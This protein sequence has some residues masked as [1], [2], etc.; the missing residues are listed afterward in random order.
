MKH[1]RFLQTAACA[2]VLFAAL[3]PRTM[4]GDEWNNRTVVTFSNA[5]QVPG[6]TLPPGTYIFKVLETEGNRYLVQ[7]SNERESHVLATLDAIPEN[8]GTAAAHRRDPLAPTEN[9]TVIT[10]YEA[11]SGQPQPVKTWYYPGQSY[12]LQFV[13]SKSEEAMIAKAGHETAPAEATAVAQSAP[14]QNQPEITPEQPAAAPETPQ[15]QAAAPEPAPAPV[16]AEPEPQPAPVATAI[17]TTP[18]PAVEQPAQD[19]PAIPEPTTLP[20]TGSQ[21]PLAGLIGLLSISAA[22]AVR[23]VRSAS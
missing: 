12:G 4:R 15:V 1:L 23:A 19:T 16:V 10:F 11:A 5:V 6:T 9:K 21:L 3:L 20:S 2:A 8:H 7:I 17:D 22:L 13:Y 18:A 14:V